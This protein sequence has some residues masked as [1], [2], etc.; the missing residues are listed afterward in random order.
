MPNWSLNRRRRVRPDK[1]YRWATLS[2]CNGCI[3]F[4]PIYAVT[5]SRDSRSVV[6]NTSGIVCLHQSIANS[7]IVSR[8]DHSVSPA[9]LSVDQFWYTQSF[10]APGLKRGKCEIAEGFLH[11]SSAHQ[12][13]YCV[14]INPASL[15]GF[16]GCGA[17]V[18]RL[19]VLQGELTG[20]LPRAGAT[21]LLR[22]TGV[23]VLD[24]CANPWRNSRL[25]DG[26]RKS[27][28]DFG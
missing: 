13:R 6:G 8:K 7:L 5:L 1:P 28:W 23:G 3:R 19:H 26:W 9:S 17:L 21:P 11:P 25:S 27:F 10:P 24:A 14:I 16:C 4:S 20:T 2:N 12:S 18:S 15:N 22:H